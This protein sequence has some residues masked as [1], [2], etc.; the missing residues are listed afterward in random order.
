[1]SKADQLGGCSGSFISGLSHNVAGS[2]GLSPLDGFALLD[3][4]LSCSG[5]GPDDDE[6]EEGLGLSSFS[7]RSAF[8][9]RCRFSSSASCPS[10]CSSS[11]PGIPAVGSAEAGTA[12]G[13]GCLPFLGA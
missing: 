11:V 8:L 5:A 4:A 9:K 7:K 12:G 3:L 1:M 13:L 2:A 10:S 6:D